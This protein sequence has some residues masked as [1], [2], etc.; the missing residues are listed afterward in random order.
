MKGCTYAIL[1]LFFFLIFLQKI[2]TRFQSEHYKIY[3]IKNKKKKTL[4][5]EKTMQVY[6]IKIVSVNTNF[7]PSTNL[8]TQATSIFI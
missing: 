1:F 3:K 6:K 8:H 5:G 4:E 2:G 7:L